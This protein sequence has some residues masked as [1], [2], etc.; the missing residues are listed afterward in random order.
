MKDKNGQGAM[1]LQKIKSDN[2]YV[3]QLDVTSD[4]SVEKAIQFIKLHSEG[5]CH[6]CSWLHIKNSLFYAYI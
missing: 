4:E 2:L 1:E 5:C 3:L 6:V